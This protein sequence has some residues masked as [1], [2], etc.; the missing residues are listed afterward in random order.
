MT[1]GDFIRDPEQMMRFADSL[2]LYIEDM[3]LACTVA[4]RH[5]GDAESIMKDKIGKDAISTLL[6]LID[7]LEAGL[8]ACDEIVRKLV[9]SAS[10]GME[11]ESTRFHSR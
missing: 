11:Y 7:D 4:R 8:P 6:Q 1:Q 3:R 5:V 9:R 10:L 2:E